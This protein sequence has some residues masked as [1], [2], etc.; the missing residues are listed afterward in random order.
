MKNKALERPVITEFMGDGF[1]LDKAHKQYLENLEL[2]NYVQA[3]DKYCDE[4][5]KLL[6]D[7]KP[8]ADTE[9]G[10]HLAD[11]NNCLPFGEWLFSNAKPACIK[12]NKTNLWQ[13]NDEAI[14]W[15]D[16]FKTTKELYNMYAKAN[17]C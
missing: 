17:C 12:D 15:N 14:N 13:L 16:R 11:V 4:L 6:S 2:W 9:R 10:L 7:G 1:T 5:E 8:D 3:L